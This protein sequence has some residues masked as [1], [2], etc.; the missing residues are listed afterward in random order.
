MII[1]LLLLILS[2]I[3]FLPECEAYMKKGVNPVSL[4][5][6]IAALPE[7]IR[8]QF[9]KKEAALTGR[10]KRRGFGSK[11]LTAKSNII[12]GFFNNVPR[13][14]GLLIPLWLVSKKNRL[15]HPSNIINVHSVSVGNK[16]ASPVTLLRAFGK[17]RQYYT[18]FGFLRF[19]LPNKIH[20]PGIKQDTIHFFTKVMN[21]FRFVLVPW[22]NIFQR[23]FACRFEKLTEKYLLSMN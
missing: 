16:T 12:P 21:C 8:L 14:S 3:Y 17:M 18:L 7:K 2:L 15:I 19:F 6:L 5:A 23:D 11:K 20:L 13:K 1:R 22:S 4:F 9:S 10:L